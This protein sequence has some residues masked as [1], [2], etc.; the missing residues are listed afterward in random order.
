MTRVEGERV[1]VRVANGG[2]ADGVDSPDRGGGMAETLTGGAVVG[3][4]EAG[5]GTACVVAGVPTLFLF[6][7]LSR[8]CRG[9]HHKSGTPSRP[10][11]RASHH[12]SVIKPPT[13]WRD[14]A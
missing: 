3:Q 4:R 13:R 2:G 8:R 10:L 7:Q 12:P 14:A 9:Q 6:L 5:G 11:D 1:A